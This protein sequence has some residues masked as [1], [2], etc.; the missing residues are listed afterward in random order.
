MFKNS[1]KRRVSI[2]LAT[3]MLCSCRSKGGDGIFKRGTYTGVSANG[4]NGEIKVEVVLSADKIESVTVGENSETAGIA[5]PAIE[6]IPERIVEAQSLDVDTVAGATITSK[7]IL[8][9]VSDAITQAGAD[10]T[11]LVA[12]TGNKEVKEE[13][14][15]ANIVVVGGGAAGLATAV[16]AAYEG[17]TDIILLEKMSALGGNAIRSGGFIEDLNPGDDRAIEMTKSKHLMKTLLKFK[18]NILR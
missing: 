17:E 10:P 11:K 14:L 3:L 2:V 6:K 9:A 13:T 7:A 5:D 18:A 15:D 16:S 4:R 1:F 8:E 12:N